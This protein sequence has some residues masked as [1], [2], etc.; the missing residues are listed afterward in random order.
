MSKNIITIQ[1]APP[2]LLSARN[3]KET[4]HAGNMPCPSCN[5][6]G[7]HWTAP[8]EEAERCPC[9]VC[10]GRGWL[11]ARVTVEWTPDVAHLRYDASDVI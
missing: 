8:Y 9:K 4:F 3:N 5:G 1:I 6:N 10:D 11:K 7:W 2:A